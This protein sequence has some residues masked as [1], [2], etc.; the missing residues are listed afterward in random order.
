MA[1]FGFSMLKSP[2]CN[3][4]ELLGQPVTFDS[5]LR[6]LLEHMCK[7]EFCSLSLSPFFE[8]VSMQYNLS[9]ITSIDF[10]ILVPEIA[11]PDTT[12]DPITH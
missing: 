4:F 8:I 3:F 6:F 12:N 1:K 7:F 9:H 5:I 11:L 2:L 10:F